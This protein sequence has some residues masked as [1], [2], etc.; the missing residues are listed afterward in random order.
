M[1]TFKLFDYIF[2]IFLITISLLF[3]PW[4]LFI[5]PAGRSADYMILG[6]FVVGGWQLISVAVH[7]I[8]KFK[9]KLR[10]I[11]LWMLLATVI[12]GVICIL[13]MILSLYYLAAL[14]FWSPV[15][16]FVYLIA[17]IKETKALKRAPAL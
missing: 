2:Q 11:Y 10:K 1:K 14:L 8:A 16:A 3:V 6:Y 15:L 4:A 5:V 13:T 9:S 7:A 17:C 12:I